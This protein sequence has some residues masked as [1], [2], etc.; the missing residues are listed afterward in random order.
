M[1]NVPGG[2]HARDFSLIKRLELNTGSGSWLCGGGKRVEGHDFT[3]ILGRTS[4][5]HKH[6]PANEKITCMYT[7]KHKCTVYGNKNRGR[8]GKLQ[9][10]QLSEK[11]RKASL[12]FSSTAV[13]LD[14]NHG[15]RLLHL[16]QHLYRS[17]HTEETE[18]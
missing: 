17:T 11:T 10:P 18:T 1:I 14:F 16:N 6:K 13:H 7:H 2:P 8:E 9:S 12:F 15:W 4:I 3:C 5:Y